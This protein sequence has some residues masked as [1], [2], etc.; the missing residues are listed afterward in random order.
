MLG[1]VV[2]VG[3]L[4]AGDIEVQPYQSE[5]CCCR[6]LSSSHNVFTLVLFFYSILIIISL[7]FKS[8]AFTRLSI[9]PRSCLLLTM[10]SMN[11]EEARLRTISAMEMEA[12]GPQRTEKMR[13]TDSKYR[14]PYIEGATLRLKNLNDVARTE[15]VNSEE[16]QKLNTWRCKSCHLLGKTFAQRPLAAAE[17]G[18][19]D[20]NL[21]GL[22]SAA[23][24]AN[25]WRCKS[26]HL[27]GKTFAQ[28]PLAAAEAGN[29][30]TNL[31]GSSSA[32]SRA[33]P[34]ASR[35]F[36][37]AGIP[38]GP[39]PSQGLSQ[40][41]AKLSKET[42][43]LSQQVAQLSKE[44]ST[45]RATLDFA[46]DKV[47]ALTIFGARQDDALYILSHKFKDLLVAHK[48]DLEEIEGQ[49]GAILA[50]ADDAVD[51]LSRPF[52]SLEELVS[53]HDDLN[54]LSTSAPLR[55]WVEQADH[56]EKDHEES[57]RSLA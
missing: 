8:H 24:Q 56:I 39:K 43:G 54:D 19:V 27:L 33:K 1:L 12:L 52:P 20:I 3:V 44:N 13:T 28:R 40:Q 5:L 22:S 16:L 51:D 21:V 18:N 45:L 46:D 49:I 48:D 6:D 42:Q 11:R 14:G 4:V 17:A 30:D 57:L 41:L 25:T 7:L 31:V 32:A 36:P 23:S 9:S 38:I 29:V 50:K 2:G 55:E 26:R 34:S 37:K 15:P 47:K 10:S 35:R 53:R